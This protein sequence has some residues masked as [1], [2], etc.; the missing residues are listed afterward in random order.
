[1]PAPSVTYTFSN[2]TTADAAE[3]NQNFTDVINGVSDGTKD[4][5]ISALTASGATNLNGNV[6]LGNASGDDLTVNASLAST[7]AVKTHNTYDIGST[8]TALR[9]IYISGGGTYSVGIKAGTASA[10]WDFTL[11]TGPGSSGQILENTGS[12]TVAWRSLEATSD[13]SSNYTVTDSD[14]VRTILATSGS[15]SGTVSSVDT[16]TDTL[17]SNSHGLSDGDTIYFLSTSHVGDGLKQGVTYFVRDSATN[18]FKVASS[19]GGSAVDIQGSGGGTITWYKGLVVTLPTASDNDGRIIKVKKVDSGSGKVVIDGE[20]S[21]NVEGDSFIDLVDHY[22]AVTLQS[23]GTEWHILDR[24]SGKQESQV[25]SH[26]GSGFGSTATK[27][28]YLTNNTTTGNAIHVKADSTHGNA[29][30]IKQDG[31]YAITYN[32]DSSSA[33]RIG[34][35]LNA[36]RGDASQTTNINSL[37]SAIRLVQG[38]SGNNRISVAV[39]VQLSAGDEIRPH[40]TG[41]ARDSAD[42]N[43]FRIVKI[44]AA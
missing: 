25:Y 36:L 26:T 11:P 41:S 13:Q 1:M 16:G 12:G 22:E 38:E 30:Y 24:H 37:S 39:T 5:S 19:P 2:G 32:D 8:V 27:I 40:G 6:T 33:I 7:I 3:V 15:T 43:Q 44:R 17:T 4:L 10:D 42:E 9:A 31:V 29:Y 20:S 34:I 21:E 14:D 18:T 28:R 35:S 23:D